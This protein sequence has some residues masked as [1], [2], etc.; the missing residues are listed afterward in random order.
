MPGALGARHGEP[1]DYHPDGEDIVGNCEG[2]GQG[3]LAEPRKWVSPSKQ[4]E[5]G[6]PFRKVGVPF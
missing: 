5:V 4:P 2:C 1:A 3:L 6:V